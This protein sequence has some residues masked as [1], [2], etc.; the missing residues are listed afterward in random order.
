MVDVLHAIL[1]NYGSRMF[2]GCLAC[3][4]CLIEWTLIFD[5]IFLFLPCS[6]SSPFLPVRSPFS[7]HLP[8]ICICLFL[9]TL[10]DK[11]RFLSLPCPLSPAIAWSLRWLLALTPALLC[12]FLTSD[13]LPSH[14]L[15]PRHASPCISIC[16]LLFLTVS[17]LPLCVPHLPLYLSLAPPYPFISNLYLLHPILSY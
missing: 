8:L 2:T 11:K 16:Q 1:V 6:L 9:S 4:S 13:R 5:H 14:H 12:S 3:W 7:L 10:H 15:C 17:L